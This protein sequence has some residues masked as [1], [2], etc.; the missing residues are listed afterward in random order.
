[1]DGRSGPIKV[2]P[3]ERV[4]PHPGMTPWDLK[5]WRAQRP[6]RYKWGRSETRPGWSQKTAAEWAG[7]TVSAWANYEQARR[8]IPLLLIKRLADYPSSLSEVVDR[9]WMTDSDEVEEN[10]GVH[11]ELKHEKKQKS[12]HHT[13]RGTG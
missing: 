7:C 4:T 11:P 9:M 6:G 2:V 3:K 1:M 12:V 13:R 8:K 5:V 10:Q